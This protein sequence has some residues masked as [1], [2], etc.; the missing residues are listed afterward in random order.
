M[1]AD[2]NLDVVGDELL[3][4][5]VLLVADSSEYL[6]AA[7]RAFGRAGFHKVVAVTSI[8]AGEN[9]FLAPQ[10][11]IALIEA[12]L[13][14]GQRSGFSLIKQIRANGLP[15]VPVV[16][17]GNRSPLHFFRTARTGAFDYLVKVPSLDLPRE[18]LRLLNGER[19]LS[20]KRRLHGST[21]D[22]GFLRQRGLTS[23][24]FL[25]ISLLSQELLR[26]EAE[27]FRLSESMDEKTMELIFFKL[28]VD[29]IAHLLRALAATE[30]FH[31]EWGNVIDGAPGEAWVRRKR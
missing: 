25:I 20:A 27:D 10:L 29:D 8:S 31:H 23:N 24:E 13:G 22:L 5:T 28:G 12:Q 1:F 6:R 2:E 7:R 18:V 15:T 17:S 11:R 30:L 21:I 19:G 9:L 26:D 4:S 14:E 3:N 16:V